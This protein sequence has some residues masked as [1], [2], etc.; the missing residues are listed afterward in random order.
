[1]RLLKTLL[2]TVVVLALTGTAFAKN[3]RDEVS[4]TMDGTSHVQ[5]GGKLRMAI[6]RKPKG[7]YFHVVIRYDAVIKSRTWLDFTA[8]PCKNTK[9][10]IPSNN[11]IEVGSGLRH[12]TFVGRV[13]AVK[14][15]DGRECV[16]AQ[17]R[18]QGP[19]RKKA[20]FGTIVRRHGHPGVRVC[21]G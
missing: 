7:K 18:D 4:V 14:G 15:S 5:A 17:V 6:S 9:C 12:L 13:R 20:G 10:L 11:H 8:Y 2:A 19:K 21:H 16:F 3:T 1:M